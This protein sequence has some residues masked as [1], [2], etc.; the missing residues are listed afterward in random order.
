MKIKTEQPL[1]P[2]WFEKLTGKEQ[3]G[4]FYGDGNFLY[5]HEFLD[6]TGITICH[7]IVH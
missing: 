4:T 7:K 3:K 1:S 5:L 6:Y 2:Q